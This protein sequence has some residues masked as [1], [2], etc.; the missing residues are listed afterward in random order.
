MYLLL[1]GLGT[2]ESV[3]IDLV[4]THTNEQL[5][6]IKDK[7]EAKAGYGEQYIVV[8]QVSETL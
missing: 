7:W 8:L 1:A 2:K 6:A 4:H 5:A 3:L